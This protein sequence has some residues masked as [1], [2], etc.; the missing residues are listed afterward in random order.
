MDHHKLQSRLLRVRALA[1]SGAT[2]GE[3][4]AARAAA[5]RLEARL[6]KTAPTR[7]APVALDRALQPSPLSVVPSTATLRAAVKDWLAGRRT[8]ED[9]AD[10]A[11]ALLDRAVLPDRP[12]DDPVSI[13]V[14]VVMLLTTLPDG[15]ITPP[16]GPALLRF[17]DAS[18]DA[19]M[20][21]WRAWFDHLERRCPPQLDRS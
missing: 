21:A 17:L 7:L 20:A 18:S 8:P 16:D 11:H 12:A 15:P 9:L 1:A 5:T 2:V 4:A 13:R 6:A 10:E 3:R 19:C 14:E